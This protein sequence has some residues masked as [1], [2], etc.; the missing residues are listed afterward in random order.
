MQN[1]QN[2]KTQVS[3]HKLGD[4]V[5]AYFEAYLPS[6]NKCGQQK[7]ITGDLPWAN[8]DGNMR[9]YIGMSISN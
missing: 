8:I 4:D 1:I 6:G 7:P 2:I 5:I 3:C 9:V